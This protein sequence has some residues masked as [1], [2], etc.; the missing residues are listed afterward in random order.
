MRLSFPYPDIILYNYLCYFQL[1]KAKLDKTP[2]I[3]PQVELTDFYMTDPISRAS[4]TMAK[5]VKAASE[6]KT[7][8]Y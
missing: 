6:A 7:A 1:V 5:C 3:P 2:L 8:K 4:Q